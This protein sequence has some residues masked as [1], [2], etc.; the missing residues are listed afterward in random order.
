MAAS[1]ETLSQGTSLPARPPALS[2]PNP[3]LARALHPRNTPRRLSL[4]VDPFPLP[5]SAAGMQ[6]VLAPTVREMHKNV[7]ACAGAQ[8]DLTAHIDRLAHELEI[9][10]ERM[11]EPA[12]E[13]HAKRIRDIRGRID[14]LCANATR[15][16]ARMTALHARA[17]GMRRANLARVVSDRADELPPRD[18]MYRDDDAAATALPAPRDGS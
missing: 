9:L 10:L 14:A 11:P 5:R 4:T 8:I 17:K 18:E 16:E 6:R 7:A 13:T 15:V 1:V 12:A 3:R 2:T